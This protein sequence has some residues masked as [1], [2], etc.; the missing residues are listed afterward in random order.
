MTRKQLLYVIEEEWYNGSWVPIVEQS[1]LEREGARVHRQMLKEKWG[2]ERR[3]RV[4]VY[5]RRES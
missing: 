5:E 3:F 4:T 2:S 1:Y